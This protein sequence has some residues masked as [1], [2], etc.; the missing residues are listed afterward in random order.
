MPHHPRLCL[1][2]VAGLVGILLPSCQSHQ[3]RVAATDGRHWVCET[4]PELQ[5]KTGY[6]RFRTAQGRDTVIKADEIQSIE[7]LN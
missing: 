1:A 2:L 5:S 7:G 6:Y 4:K 3:Y